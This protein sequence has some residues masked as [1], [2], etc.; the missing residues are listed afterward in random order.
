MMCK[1][2]DNGNCKVL[3]DK[4][5]V[6]CKTIK[7]VSPDVCKKSKASKPEKKRLMNRKEF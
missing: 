3:G 7:N 1:Y 4:I 2:Y 6:A 5:F